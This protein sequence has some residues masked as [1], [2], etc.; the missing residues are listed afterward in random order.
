ML[1]QA[2]LKPGKASSSLSVAD[3]TNLRRLSP[4]RMRV[5]RIS[6]GG[7]TELRRGLLQQEE[8]IRR[9]FV[10]AD[11]LV[12]EESGM[13]VNIET[14][15]KGSC[16]GCRRDRE[17]VEW[18]GVIRGSKRRELS[19]ER[20]SRSDKYTELQDHHLQRLNQS[21][22]SDLTT[23]Q[24]AACMAAESNST[25][26]TSSLDEDGCLLKLQPAAPVAA[27]YRDLRRGDDDDNDDDEDDN[28]SKPCSNAVPASAC[29]NYDVNK[30]A[31][32]AS[33]DV[34]NPSAAACVR[35]YDDH[36]PNAGEYWLAA[37]TYDVKTPAA[38]CAVYDHHQ[39]HDAGDEWLELRLGCNFDASSTAVHASTSSSPSL[40]TLQLLP[41]D[42][43]CASMKER[44]K[45]TEQLKLCSGDYTRNTLSYEEAELVK[46]PLLNYND[47]AG[48]VRENH[49]FYTN[50]MQTGCLPIPTTNTVGQYITSCGGI[51]PNLY[52][53]SAADELLYP[54]ILPFDHPPHLQAQQLLQDSSMHCRGTPLHAL[55]EQVSFKSMSSSMSSPTTSLREATTAPPQQQ[56][57]VVPRSPAI[58]DFF[59][60][61]WDQIGP[62]STSCSILQP[63]TSFR[64]LIASSFLK[65]PSNMSTPLMTSLQGQQPLGD[66][67]H[68]SWP[69]KILQSQDKSTRF[70]HSVPDH[71][72]FTVNSME[73]IG[74]NMGVCSSS[75]RSMSSWLSQALSAAAENHVHQRLLVDDHSASP[76]PKASSIVPL[77][78]S[79]AKQN[80]DRKQ[81]G[82][83]LL[84][85]CSSPTSRGSPGFWFALQRTQPECCDGEVKSM[86][87][88]RMK[89]GDV[90]ISAVKKFLVAK[91]GLSNESQ[92]GLA[93][94]G[95]LLEERAV[96]KSIREDIWL[97][98]GFGDHKETLFFRSTTASSNV[99]QDGLMILTYQIS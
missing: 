19:V 55:Q 84:K 5:S 96:L 54:K 45:Q 29:A 62:S 10:A 28:S 85:C 89:D 7:N 52:A 27:G 13:T 56:R 9:S 93:C 88:I 26:T 8:Y 44:E 95:Q 81:M 17:D 33:R 87:Y 67:S 18:E 30:A 25:R 47:Q 94:R 86:S 37:A 20:E 79:S 60:Q 70:D 43:D 78:S 98:A 11:Q 49:L 75:S 24:S 32:C 77:L 91:L 51:M 99:P 63:A 14:H 35:L 59:H 36:R 80:G 31:A 15:F 2:F 23:E 21:G 64:E 48:S 4:A 73:N 34:N 39:A 97:G 61:N 42:P 65:E 72:R 50:L 92:V 3:H 16:K 71:Q 1:Q 46:P 82:S 12:K 90:P 53:S 58:P 69:A 76:S 74:Y 41:Q 66:I 40:C 83:P 68:H 57:N 22:E 38:T 6:S